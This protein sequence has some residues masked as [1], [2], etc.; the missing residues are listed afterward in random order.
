MLVKAKANLFDLQKISF[1]LTIRLEF[2]EPPLAR[3]SRDCSGKNNPLHIG[4]LFGHVDFVKEIL[5]IKP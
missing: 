1:L 2:L 5:R 3:A 4:A